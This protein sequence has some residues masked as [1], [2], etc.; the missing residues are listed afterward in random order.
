MA[1]KVKIFFNSECIEALVME[2][3]FERLIGL[4]FQ[5]KPSGAK[6]LIFK[7]AN[8]IHSFFVFF[9]FGAIYLDGNSA[10]KALK[11]NIPPFLVLKPVFGAQCVIEFVNC[12]FDVKIGDKII[13]DEH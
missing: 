9:K 7:N 11:C 3:F 1:K 8:W 2:N 5:S 4:M 6:V 13:I 12:C 10:V